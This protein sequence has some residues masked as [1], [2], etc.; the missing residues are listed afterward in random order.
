[1]PPTDSINSFS[2]KLAGYSYS[3]TI[4]C[5]AGSVIGALST[6]ALNGKGATVMLEFI[7]LGADSTAWV[8]WWCCSGYTGAIIS[9]RN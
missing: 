8:V 3:N 9:A 4:G 2:K 7:A 1:M 5:V 6:T